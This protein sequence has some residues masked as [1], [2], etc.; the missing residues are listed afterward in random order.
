[1]NIQEGI[2]GPVVI[3]TDL[4]DVYRARENMDARGL[5]SKFYGFMDTGLRY[6]T[7]ITT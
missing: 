5:P 2:S 7:S 4:L 3:G 1:M 6:W